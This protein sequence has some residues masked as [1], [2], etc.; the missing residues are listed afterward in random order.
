MSDTRDEMPAITDRVLAM[1][2]GHANGQPVQITH[3]SHG[4]VSL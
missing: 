1:V 3:I 4:T 2:T